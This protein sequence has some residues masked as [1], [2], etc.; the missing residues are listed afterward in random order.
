[1]ANLAVVINGQKILDYDRNKRLPGIQRRFLDEMDVRMRTE[2]IQLGSEWVPNPGI[3]A[4]AQYVANLLIN[5]LLAE[6]DARAAATCAWLATRLPDLQQVRA[7]SDAEG[8]RIELTF[9]R[10]FEQTQQEQK[11]NFVRLKS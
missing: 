11:L 2:G 1:M 3:D 4:C 10:S 7:L 8:M 6:Q 5:A 9:D